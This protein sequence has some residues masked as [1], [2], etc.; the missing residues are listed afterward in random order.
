[1]R[2]LQRALRAQ[3][4]LEVGALDVAHGDEQAAVGLAGLV[5]RD[6]VRMVDRRRELGL[7]QEPLAKAPSDAS[8]GASTFSAT[9]RRSRRSSPGT[10]RS[11]RR[12]RAAPRSDSRRCAR[13]YGR[14]P[15]R[16][17]SLGPW[18]HAMVLT[19]LLRAGAILLMQ[20]ERECMADSRQRLGDTR[21]ACLCAVRSRCRA[22]DHPGRADDHD[23]RDHVSLTELRGQR[24]LRDA[25]DGVHVERTRRAP[26]ASGSRP[27]TRWRPA[28]ANRRNAR[29]A[30]S[31]LAKTSTRLSIT[32]TP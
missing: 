24:E 3:E 14:R 13:R 12:A 29:R 19:S 1:M 10:R 4:R 22:G 7:A 11:C 21:I 20:R 18:S 16:R 25:G 5:D 9:R 23:A 28:G 8:S 15:R 26:P 6:D 17:S 31:A 2:R 27:E 30:P 32:S